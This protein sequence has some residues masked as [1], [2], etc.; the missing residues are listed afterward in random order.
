MCMGIDQ[1]GNDRLSAAIN[2]LRR[3]V[4]TQDARRRANR[5]HLP[6]AH[7][8]RAIG[9]DLLFGVHRDHDAAVYN[10][11]H[12]D[13]EPGCPF[14]GESLLIVHS[15][16]LKAWRPAM[17]TSAVMTMAEAT[18]HGQIAFSTNSSR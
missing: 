16:L 6:L 1:A 10:G 15:A 9:H 4:T 8:H 12:A 13:H 7:S 14:T 2:H 11:V 3:L 18:H 5:N 17:T